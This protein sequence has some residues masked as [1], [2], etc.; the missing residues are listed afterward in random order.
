ME[1]PPPQVWWHS[2]DLGNGVVTSG[3]DPTFQKIKRIKLPERLDGLSV[4]DVGAWDGAFSFE[5]EK[6]GAKR[7]LATDSFCWSGPGW[8]TKAGF[9]YARQ[10]LESKVE[11]LEIDPME[12]SPER[13]GKFDLVL[14]LGVMYH[15]RHPLLA[16]EK[17]ASVAAHRLILETHIE[18]WRGPTPLMVFYP[19]KECNN[20]PTNW[21]G[22]NLPAV[23]AILKDVGFTRVECVFQPTS[24]GALWEYV[25]TPGGN[26]LNPRWG[27][28]V[29]HAWR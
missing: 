3:L 4:L 19:G 6:R 25:K 8:G 21:W 7:V 18:L 26:R 11:D 10:Q 13:V 9:L 14:Y 15:M 20:D 23:K 22:P 16:L 29:F 28:A 5:C 17:V 1:H 27:R 12:L 2:I 24:F